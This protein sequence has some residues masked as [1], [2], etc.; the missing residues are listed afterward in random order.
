MSEVR[1]TTFG[2]H[3]EESTLSS[4]L[5]SITS[6][7]EGLFGDSIDWEGDTPPNQVE[8]LREPKVGSHYYVP[9]NPMRDTVRRTLSYANYIA[10]GNTAIDAPA[11]RENTSIYTAWQTSW[12]VQGDLRHRWTWPRRLEKDLSTDGI[13]G[14]VNS[15]IGANFTF[16]T[17]TWK[18]IETFRKGENSVAWI[19]FE[20]FCWPCSG[21]YRFY[22][23]ASYV[24]KTADCRKRYLPVGYFF[25]L[26]ITSPVGVMGFSSNLDLGR[27]SLY[28]TGQEF[29][30]IYGR[31]YE[32]DSDGSGVWHQM[33]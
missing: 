15:E 32:D 28:T 33:A 3:G 5:S 8:Y 21:L 13:E 30:S 31:P 25:P 29:F 7:V 2:S 23:A 6:S 4:I 16:F 22:S 18:G 9:I 1:E 24:D 27:L 19:P 10:D 17:S 11:G 20:L 26:T 12:L 14:C